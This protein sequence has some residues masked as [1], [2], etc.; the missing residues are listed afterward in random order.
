MR[1]G[2]AGFILLLCARAMPQSGL[3][4]ASMA[5]TSPMS[6]T[7]EMSMTSPMLMTTSMPMTSPLAMT[8]SMTLT[9]G[10]G[11]APTGSAKVAS[12]ND[13]GAV[14]KNAD[15]NKSRERKIFD[16][17]KKAFTKNA[18]GAD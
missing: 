11:A 10:N 1:T 14:V 9:T 5:L 17:W 15:E 16:I 3:N 13:S 2:V 4:T 8:T 6:M 12:V 18:V 7:T